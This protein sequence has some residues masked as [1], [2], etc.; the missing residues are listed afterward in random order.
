MYTGVMAIG[1]GI[2]LR[3]ATWTA[4]ALLAALVVFFSV[5]ARWEESRL[6]DAYT[7]YASYQKETGRFLPRYGRNTVL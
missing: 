4:L 6:A 1:L 3:T 5:K 7:G 2:T